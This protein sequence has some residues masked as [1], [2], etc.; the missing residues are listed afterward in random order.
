[1]TNEQIRLYAL[2]RVVLP[3]DL[4]VRALRDDA[5]AA[6][7]GAIYTVETIDPDGE[8]RWFGLSARQ[9]S[10]F[11]DRVIAGAIRRAFDK[12]H[13]RGEAAG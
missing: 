9:L 6:V 13:E 2:A 5:P 7:G 3:T 10:D 4:H 11:P 1:M 8:R 12:P